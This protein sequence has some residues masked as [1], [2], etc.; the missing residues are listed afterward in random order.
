VPRWP[1]GG[2]CG[3]TWACSVPR[4]GAARWRGYALPRDHGTT[5]LG[6]E[7]AEPRYD[8]YVRVDVAAA[9]HGVSKV[10]VRGD[11]CICVAGA[12]GRVPCRALAPASGRRICCNLHGLNPRPPVSA[13]WK[14]SSYLTPMVRIGSENLSKRR[15]ER[16]REREKERERGRERDRERQRDRER[17]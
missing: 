6:S 3:V 12:A 9:A 8:F 5:Y 1:S 15:R 7:A 17:E 11:C 4:V 14:Q 10:E 16:E 13:P 2:W